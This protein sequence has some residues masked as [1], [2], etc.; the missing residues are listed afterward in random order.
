MKMDILNILQSSKVGKKEAKEVGLLKT[1]HRIY[2]SQLAAELKSLAK[3][4]FKKWKKE[5]KHQAKPKPTANHNHT[6]P[7]QTIE[8]KQAV[9]TPSIA[10]TG[11]CNYDF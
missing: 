7:K 11:E 1:V 6:T 10:I 9:E 4:V 8:T 3:K 5:G 2:K